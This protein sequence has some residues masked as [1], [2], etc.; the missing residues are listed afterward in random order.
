MRDP[1]S[2]DLTRRLRSVIGRFTPGTASRIEVDS[3]IRAPGVHIEATPVRPPRIEPAETAVTA[4]VGRAEQGPTDQPVTVRSAADFARQFGPS[5]AE[6]MLGRSIGA[7]FANGGT[8]AL[9]VRVPEEPAPASSVP[10]D[11]MAG[12]GLH[13]LDGQAFNLLCIP[14]FEA[15]T[16]VPKAVWDAAAAFCRDRRAFLIVDSPRSWASVGMVTDQAI[17]A[18][19]S[20]SPDAAIYFPWLLVP[21]AEGTSGSVALAPSGAVAGVI[22][23]TDRARG[24]WK[25]PAGAEAALTG[26]TG[27]GLRL[28]DVD[29][30]VINPRGVNAIREM[31]GRGVLVWGARTMAGSDA[32]SSEWKYVNVRRTALYVEESIRRGT[33]WAV[34]E[35]N[36]EPLWTSLRVAAEEFL[37]G[38]WRGGGLAGTKP[39]HAFFVRCD[40]TT[41][42]E[43]DLAEGRVVLL[44]GLALVRPAE[45]V[46]LRI[47]LAAGG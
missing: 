8:T 3:G 31:V 14:P 47:S 20:R 42:T 30:G 46:T 26:I 6:G 38:L 29:N 39:E 5:L 9:V 37:L 21:S 23:R 22:A 10:G 12:T 41:M 27:V 36:A 43:A 17:E 4:F 24:V 28:S 7:F 25:A 19:A 32:S 40:R 11:P 2:R 44:L 15:G 33:G 16:D 18:V 45:F 34:S 35:P 13:A 1:S